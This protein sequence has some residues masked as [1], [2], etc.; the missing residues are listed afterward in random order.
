MM[1]DILLFL[2]R[3]DSSHELSLVILLICR[4]CQRIRLQ[5]DIVSNLFMHT[6][7]VLVNLLLNIGFQIIMPHVVDILA[8]TAIFTFK[9]LLIKH[10]SL[11]KHNRSTMTNSTPARIIALSK[12]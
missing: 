8:T 12:F 7:L 5:V 10:Q 9:F 1:P 3:E 2:F 4:T 11:L 6:F